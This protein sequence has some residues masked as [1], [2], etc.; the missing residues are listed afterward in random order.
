MNLREIRN[1]SESEKLDLINDFI[2]FQ[3]T[4]E[5]RTWNYDLFRMLLMNKRLKARFLCY[6]LP[7]CFES[8][9]YSLLLKNCEYQI[10]ENSEKIAFEYPRFYV[11]SALC[12]AIH[13]YWEHLSVKKIVSRWS[14]ILLGIY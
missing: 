9:D 3:D 11:M 14:Q 1:Y 7:F 8:L 2:D 6:T 5:S 10:Q 4:W 12:G 13:C